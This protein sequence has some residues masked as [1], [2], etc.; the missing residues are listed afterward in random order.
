MQNNIYLYIFTMSAV[1][2]LIRLIPLAI[3]RRE[4]KNRFVISFL[5]Y[6]PY[7]ALAVMTFPSILGATGN[8]YSSLIGFAAALITAYFDGNLFKVAIASSGA[9][10]I[11]GL[12]IGMI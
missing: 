6:L 5:H 1:T 4:F 9:A 10:L 2:Y 3:F 8:I 11:S 12:I 7:A